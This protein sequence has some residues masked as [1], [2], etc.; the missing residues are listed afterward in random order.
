MSLNSKL[1]NYAWGGAIINNYAYNTTTPNNATAVQRTD[2]VAET[3]LFL[4]QGKYLDSLVPSETL[5]TVSFGINDNGQYQIA[6]GDLDLAYNTYVSKL[7]A[8]QSNGATN[9]LIQGMYKSYNDTN[10]LQ[11]KVFAYMRDAHLT[12]GTNFAFV[13]LYRLFSTILIS[14]ASF[15]YSGAGNSTCL[16][17]ASTTVGGCSDPDLEVFF[18][19]GHPSSTTHRLMSEYTMEVLNTCSS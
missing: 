8:L 7:N 13:D 18:I 2:F 9:I 4:L 17:S 6:G 16:I 14:P 5:Y 3:A 19:P 11:N 12:N 10:T 15:G 1:L